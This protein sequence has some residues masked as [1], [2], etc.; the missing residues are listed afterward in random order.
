[1]SGLNDLR[2]LLVFLSE[3]SVTK[4]SKRLGITQP[5][6]SNALARLRLQFGD[7]LL[8]P[9]RAGMLVT[10]RAR[11]IESEAHAL[12][13]RYD[14]LMQPAQSFDPASSRRKFVLTCSQFAEHILIPELFKLLRKE[15]PG[16]HLE[17][18]PPVPSSIHEWLESGR[19]DL[20]IA[21]PYEPAGSLR[22]L[23]LAQDRIVCIADA[24]HP[25]IDK[26]LDLA[27][28]LALPQVQHAVWGQKSTIG[29]VVEE[30][31][32]SRGV[33]LPEVLLIQNFLTIPDTIVG[34]DLIAMIPERIGIQFARNY[35]LRLWVPPIKL[36]RT[37]YAAYWHERSH[38]DQGHRW[39][40]NAVRIVARSVSA[41]A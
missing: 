1:M 12:I 8:L 26:Q 41:K 24:N 29:R 39:L 33:R 23:P 7:P 4:A 37:K 14:A 19:V 21:W 2:T 15:A 22:F 25:L 35:N 40:R 11:E 38:K 18:L 36:P 13:D 27:T 31:F 5:A 32:K 16:V 17:V 9:S 6:A 3:R 28:F 30:A 34:S 20:R 10:D